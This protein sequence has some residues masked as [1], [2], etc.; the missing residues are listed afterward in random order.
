MAGVAAIFVMA[1]LGG[2]S[3]TMG[4]FFEM[5]V[6]MAIYLGGVLVNWRNLSKNVQTYSG[7][8]YDYDNR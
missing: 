8:P 7:F 1:S 4:V 2:T 5:Q 6:A 3:T